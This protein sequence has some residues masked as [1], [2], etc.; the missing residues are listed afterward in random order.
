MFCVNCGSEISK[1]N[2]F[3]GNCGKKVKLSSREF[4][5]NRERKRNSI[6]ESFEK[7]LDKSNRISDEIA[8]SEK[9]N[10]LRIS[11]RNFLFDI[12]KGISKFL[13][14]MAIVLFISYFVIFLIKREIFLTRDLELLFTNP[15]IG[16]ARLIPTY[17][18]P[19]ILILFHKQDSGTRVFTVSLFLLVTG[20]MFMNLSN[21]EIVQ[22]DVNTSETFSPSENNNLYNSD[23]DLETDEV[24]LNENQN[25]YKVD[26]SSKE[27][28]DDLDLSDF[29][30]LQMV[31][32]KTYFYDTANFEN[33]KNTFLVK[34]DIFKPLDFENGFYYV[35]F[36]NHK[37]N[38]T[39]GW[40][41]G[42][43]VNSYKKI[44]ENIDLNSIILKH[45]RI[46]EYFNQC[47]NLELKSIGS[48][49]ADNIQK[50]WRLKNPT[51]SEILY[52]LEENWSTLEY[53]Y[54]RILSIIPISQDE[55]IVT[56]NYTYKSIYD[57]DE[58]GIISKILIKING[59][60]EI[61]FINKY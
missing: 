50:F 26:T 34:G 29:V 43:Y 58:K 44:L 39:T 56:T 15:S 4:E 1:G 61:Y 42:E 35:E 51:K 17:I 22:T 13:F 55:F 21:S 41:N 8:Q 48:Y 10:N 33:R 6:D 30:N 2:N 25:I 5:E 18:L 40:I 20:L 45:E 32:D 37:G 16:F 23:N 14:S 57:I 60:N 52:F 19:S 28:I 7:F 9:V 36:E 46:L 53:N 54:N 11:T 27:T 24:V 49:F 12:F 38:I 59:E 47:D 31:T 3:C